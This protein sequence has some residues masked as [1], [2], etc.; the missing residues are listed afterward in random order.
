MSKNTK[1]IAIVGGVLIVALLAYTGLSGGGFGAAF[2]S[3]GCGGKKDPGKP[4]ANVETFEL[5][6]CQ[7]TGFACVRE[8]NGQPKMVKGTKNCERKPKDYCAKLW[9][10]KCKD[11]KFKAANKSG[12]DKF[13]K[14][15][16][17]DDKD[18][19]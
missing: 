10:N 4:R 5:T 12:C 8:A 14:A 2:E 6:D 3:M 13:G 16:A 19:D 11:A 18:D 17:D 15:A 7:N 9:G 1:I